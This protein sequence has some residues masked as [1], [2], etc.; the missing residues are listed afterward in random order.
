MGVTKIPS[1][2]YSIPLAH[3]PLKEGEQGDPYARHVKAVREGAVDRAVKM[4]HFASSSPTGLIDSISA[5]ATFHDLGKLDPENQS[6]L[7]LFRGG[8][9]HWD[10]IDAGVAHL[11]NQQEWIAAWL[12]RAHHA[13]GFPQ[14]AEHFTEKTN[15]RLRGRR[16]D[17]AP[18]ERHEEQIKHT[19]EKISDYL[20]LHESS[21]GAF[22]I[23]KKRPVHGLSLRLALS[24]LVDAD[25]SDSA[26]F[27]IGRRL[28]EPAECRWAE[29]LKALCNYVQSL[30]A[31]ENEEER[32]RNQQRKLF[33][34]ACLNSDIPDPMVACE[35][36][37]GLGKTTAVAAYLLK[38]AI[39][40]GLRRLIIIAPFTNI[41]SQTAERL[42]RALVLPGEQPDHVVVEHHHRAE[43]SG[44][45]EREFAVLWNAP[46]VLT[47]A[48]SFFDTLSSR[49]PA[50]LRKLHAVPG[51][52]IFL[53]EAHAAIPTPLWPQNW[54]W[55]KELAGNWGCKIVFASGSL[56]RF[57]ENEDIVSPSVHLRELMPQDQM[58]NVMKNE[59]RRISYQQAKDGLVLT[60]KDLIELATKKTGPRLIIL[61]TVKNAALVAHKMRE[62]RLDVLHLSNALTPQDRANILERI[63]QKL[64]AEEYSDWTLVAT[65]SVEAG[66][67]FSFRNAFRERFSASSIIQVGGRVN[68]NGE[69]NDT[70]GGNV[71][72]F[73]LCDEG[74]TQHPA[75]AVSG[76]ILHDFLKKGLFNSKNPADIVTLSMQ[77]EL[78][79]QG[80][81]AADL[82]VKAENER[83]YPLVE[84]LGRVIQNDT[85]FVVIDSQLQEL[86]KSGIPIGFKAILDGSIQMWTNRIDKLG[87]IPFRGREEIYFWNDSYDPDFLGYMDAVIRNEKI[88][89]DSGAWII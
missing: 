23:Q 83:D 88:M 61:N 55:M 18:L 47:T 1:N 7:R 60:I 79:N 44:R 21:V 69:Y 40:N 9:L 78:K 38:R 22:P 76:D 89:N 65:S 62:R 2:K 73:T 53:D 50:A 26:F 28:A 68:R 42:R 43:F 25:H 75:A 3:S 11:T 70:G 66:V 45:D 80:G 59:R 85:R 82:L 5:A 16:R 58:S 6:V 72:D 87:L 63:E 36:P 14:K 56:V 52:A 31:A 12:V 29:R 13:P 74:V 48:V 34:E 15:R 71:F 67:D 35:G 84:K 39:Q 57:W 17:N 81:L 33:F 37:V 30:S 24:C 86:M 4:L 27:D 54:R 10:H 46:I 20:L 8:R 19:D 77:M 41:L 64:K 51:S 32:I 49:S